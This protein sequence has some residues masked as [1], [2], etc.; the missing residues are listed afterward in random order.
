MKQ[1]IVFDLDGTLV[2]SLP[3]IAEG[4]NRA[5]ELL[6]R[7]RRAVEDIRSMIGRGARN[8]CAQALGYP[9]AD[10]APPEELEPMHEHF[11]HCYAHCWRGRFTRPYPGITEVLSTLARR[12]VK[13]AV[14][15]NKPHEITE[16]MVRE[17]FTNIPFNPIL[18]HTGE[19]PRKPAPDALLHIAELWEVPLQQV[20]LVGDSLYDV[21]TAQNAGCRFVAVAWGYARQ[22]ELCAASPLPPAKD[23]DELLS[24]L[25]DNEYSI[26]VVR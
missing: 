18:G 12:G 23:A 1:G 8:L 11:R 6:G 9:D 15:S 19:F 4:V 14:L 3:G 25:L 20:I 22:N 17:L 2:D 26:S 7:P 10:H 13:M 16:P 24:L 5:L 21:G